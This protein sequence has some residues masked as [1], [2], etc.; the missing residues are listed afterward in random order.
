MSDSSSYPLGY[1]ENE[2]R[3]LAGQ[4]A[5]FEDLTADVFKRAG[6][7]RERPQRLD[8]GLDYER[9]RM[10]RAEGLWKTRFATRLSARGE[11]CCAIALARFHNQ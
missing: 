3:R 10:R 5:H 2:A 6:I 9:V 4:A 7:A 1:T 11:S 8:R